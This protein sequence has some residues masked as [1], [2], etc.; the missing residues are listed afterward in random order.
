MK[1]LF[2][3][4]VLASILMMSC[5]KDFIELNPISSVS[6]NILFKT[7][8]DF[9]AAIVGC[10]AVFQPEYGNMWLYGDLPGEDCRYGT[11]DMI[12]SEIDKFIVSNS[13]GHLL[14]SW[15]NYYNII[16]RANTVLSKI[17]NADALVVINKDQYVGEAKFLRALA[18]FNL[19][20]IFGDVP[21]LTTPITVEEAY[22]TGRETVAIIYNE[23][24][25][26]DLL[27]AENKLPLKYSGADVG[28]ATKGAA[29]A[30]LGKVYIT[31]H[32]FINA[33]SKLQEL[34]VAPF[35]YALLP[36]Y[37][38]LWDYSKDEHH[39]EYIFDIEYEQG[40]GEGSSFT[41]QFSLS[42]QGGGVLCN[43]MVMMYGV[44]ADGGSRGC[45]ADILFDAYDPVD[46]RK[47][48]SVAKGLTYNGVYTAISTTGAGSFCKK[49]LTS[50]PKAN[51]SKAN[52][53]V[54][55]YADVLLMYAEALN[56]NGKTPEAL[57][58][59]NLVRK[60]AGV[61]SYSGLTQSVARDKIL[62]ERRFEL[63]L[64]GHRWF[65]LVRTGRALE[66]MAPYGMKPYM[67]IFPIPQTQV[68]IINNPKV[69]PQNP[70][71]L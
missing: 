39:S 31:T 62:D 29:K 10:Y 3:L 43:V 59:L 60:R 9:K 54:I 65:D 48:I 6:T 52:W 5:K 63:Y 50:I 15:Q 26:P 35:T 14:S 37:N 40:I 1:N 53:K 71:Y 38:S 13:A 18:Y 67:T 28:K 19:V 32:D 44:P 23:V 46:L 33:E 8:K 64:E 45:P 49:Y 2:S 57:V 56:E 66:L 61:V 16:S 41:S 36:N 69:F 34:T 22:I 24:I 70:G 42:F 58:V 51:D 25:I 11:N 30:L 12:S 4:L 55:R 47:D 17:E 7:D 21:K 20:R 68:E 27:D